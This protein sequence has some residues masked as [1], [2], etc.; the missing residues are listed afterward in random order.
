MSAVCTSVPRGPRRAGGPPCPSA[1]AATSNAG[2]RRGAARA[3]IGGNF[4]LE[5]HRAGRAVL[6]SMWQP[7]RIEDL[8]DETGGSVR[9]LPPKR[10]R[11]LDPSSSRSANRV[12]ANFLSTGMTRSKSPRFA[13]LSQQT[14]ALPLPA[15]YRSVFSI[16]HFSL[17]L[18]TTRVWYG[19]SM[20]MEMCDFLAGCDRYFS[21]SQLERGELWA[22]TRVLR[23]LAIPA[24]EVRN[25]RSK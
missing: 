23:D 13:G 11:M 1:S 18:W 21:I 6:I 14:S 12:V 16:G 7:R 20:C 17:D 2:G 4:D 25:S 15:Q 3:Q 24:I 9:R 22:P 10:W 8:A 5:Q 19:F